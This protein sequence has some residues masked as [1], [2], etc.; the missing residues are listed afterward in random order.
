VYTQPGEIKLEK[1]NLIK[2]LPKLGEEWEISFDFKPDDY[3]TEGYTS[4]LHLSIND[5]VTQIGDRIPAIFYHHI[6]GLHISTAIGNDPNSHRDVMPAPPVGKWTSI[7]V[8]QLKTGSTPTVSVK[9]DGAD[10]F[11]VENPAPTEFSDVKVY[12]ADPWWDAQPGSI[13]GLNIKTQ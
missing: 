8:S 7:V 9:A 12:A 2:T 5:D 1:D 13:R 3:T 11:S 4:I 10:P 6:H